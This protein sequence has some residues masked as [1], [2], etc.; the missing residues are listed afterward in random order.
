MADEIAPFSGPAR[1]L[2]QHGVLD[3][4]NIQQA[5]H[6]CKV[7][8]KNLISYLVDE[9]M[10]S[11][12][13]I[14]ECMSDDFSI[15]LLNLASFDTRQLPYELVS[16]KLIKQHKALPLFQRDKR[17]FLG[18]SDPTQ[19]NG[20]NEIRFHT[21]LNVTPILLPDDQLTAGM[22]ALLNNQNNSVLEHLDDLSNTDL[23]TI[24]ISSDEDEF[25]DEGDDEDISSNDA[26]IVRFVSKLII[27]AINL[28]ASDIH[29]EPYEK[30]FRVRYRRDGVLYE[31]TRPP[32]NM[33]VRI[34]S[35][36]KVMASLDIS[37]RRVP[38]DG[39]FK[40]KLSRNR[41][42]GFRIN[43]CPTLFGEKVVLRVL[44]PA[45][46]SMGIE[47]LGF[48][49]VQRKMFE[50]A[51]QRPQGM[52]L[53]TGPTGSGK[54]VTLYT[55]LNIVNTPEKNI[56]TAEDPVE[57]YQNGINQVN[58]NVKTGLTFATALRAFLR[59]DPDIIM[60]G[61]IR[62]TETAEIGIKAAQTGHLVLSTLHT[63]SAADTLTRLENMGV[64]VYNI[65]TSVAL[66]IAQ[67]LVRRLCEH[68]KQEADIPKEAL[69]EEGFLE[70]EIK[71]LKLYSPKGC[72]HCTKGYKGRVG[73]YEVLPVTRAIERII[74]SNGSA[75]DIE[76][77]AIKEGMI[78]LRRAGLNK[79]A[80]G[81]TSLEEI[82]RATKE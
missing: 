63:N 27:D 25:M 29:F 9:N 33:A 52:I 46:A 26:P 47:A 30:N 79:T 74:M 3:E 41:S 32:N 56:S 44:D 59:Q 17:L 35:R 58:I 8:H 80:E 23:D 70:D 42:V 13:T 82:N 34:V 62:D 5:L 66:V 7:Q 39:R 19:V 65:A 49:D 21:G 10:A 75:L 14:A 31:V 38:Q 53:V 78:D 77:R 51:I 55:A 76:D 81:V 15:P 40:M 36:L 37:E 69:L 61:E 57:I 43:T 64:A 12:I 28:N 4:Q 71:H 22:E 1:T 68:C 73:I 24:D 16:E 2:L 60:L 48:T 6:E 45:V 72:Q 11:A 18:I 67:R 20:V 54:T 50:E